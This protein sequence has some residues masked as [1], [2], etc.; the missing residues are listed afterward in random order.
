MTEVIY[1]SQ[2]EFRESILK[3]RKRGGAYQLAANKAMQTIENLRLGI[4]V[5]QLQTNNGE[6]R[7]KNAV[8]YDLGHACRLVT[9]QSNQMI[10]LLYVG[11]HDE[12]EH[13][14]ERHKGLEI[15]R[16]RETNEI[17]M[18]L[19]TRSEQG[20]QRPIPQEKQFTQDNKP[21]LKRI[22][23]FDL[24]EWVNQGFLAR[25]LLALDENSSDSDIQELI[26]D[27]AKTDQK[28]AHFL[29]DLICIIKAGEI[30]WI[31]AAIARVQT[32]KGLTMPIGEDA[33]AET[34]ALDALSNSQRLKKF[35]GMPMEEIDR[36]LSPGGFRDWKYF[37]YPEQKAVAEAEYDK[38]TVFTGVS[39]SGKTVVLVH[40]ARYLARKYPG[41]RIG[42]VTLSRSLARLISS[43]LDELCNPETRINIHVLAFYDLFKEIVKELGPQAYLD[44]LVEAAKGHDDEREIINVFRNVKPEFFARE[45]DPLSKEEVESDTWDLFIDQASVQTQLTYLHEYLENYQWNIDSEQYLREELSLL[46][47]AFP[48]QLR[49]TDYLAHERS[50]RAIRF[51]EGIRQ[52]ILHLATLW[53]ETMLSGGLLDVLSLTSALLPNLARIK[54]LPME[55]RFR[56]LLIDE[57]QDFSTLDLSL[58]RRLPTHLGENGLFLTGD[59]VQRVLVKDLRLGAVGLDIIS[60]NRVRLQ[61]NFRN[62]KQILEAAYLLVRDFGGEAQ[63]M[64]EEVE[65][66]DPELTVRETAMPIVEHVESADEIQRA[67][68]IVSECLASE[69]TMA[70][71][72][73]IC[74]A[75]PE[76]IP[77]KAIIDAKP[78]SLPVQARELTGD[79]LE[80]EQTVSIATMAELKG[81]EFT[82]VVIV[83]CG[84]DHL[85]LPGRC[86]E[87]VWRDALRLYVAMTRARDSIYLL[88]SGDPSP[89]LMPMSEKVTWVPTSP[90]KEMNK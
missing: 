11:T 48:V 51:T 76:K 79:Y 60:A 52:R 70:W 88:H 75:C 73:T 14:I 53:E 84:A 42:V 18:V 66:I 13:W 61:K 30:G 41:E 72:V 50:G 90:E 44:Q 29:F 55:K 71:S 4:D 7:I 9:V 85:P 28:L 12:A 62:S 6:S 35:S 82:L 5:S 47:S 26:Q 27:I 67:W 20:A 36:L 49:R 38:P 2:S 69:Q 89:I 25:P 54:E 31:D 58:L 34:E 3:L 1:L 8:K 39:G 37:L 63:K 78:T 10:F 22:P 15:T 24:S 23:G 80:N 19:L 16:H 83:G 87:E 64:G 45:Y 40:R 21:F 81:F 77:V 59:P 86:K 46:R 17:R 57:F 56:C 32:E 68:E 33:S 65:I 43:Q 74:T